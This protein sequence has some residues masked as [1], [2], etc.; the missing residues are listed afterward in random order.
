MIHPVQIFHAMRTNAPPTVDSVD[1]GHPARVSVDRVLEQLGRAIGAVR[2]AR[3]QRLLRLGI[4]MTHLHVLTLLRHHGPQ[5]M[6]RVA[7]L[8][9]GSMS[10]TTGVIDRMEE[11]GLVER[12]RVP[13]DRRV[14]LVRPTPDGESLVDDVE[15]VRSEF[16]R[17]VLGRLDAEQLGRLSAA[18]DDLRH[19][20]EDELATISDGETGMCGHGL[21]AIP[22]GHSR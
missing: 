11:R 2:C 3:S 14:V 19:A 5:P 16:A 22:G 9:D 6:S 20:V 15:I 1:D 17:S 21:G 10:G 8:L 7:A 18:I 4:S 13:E 12:F